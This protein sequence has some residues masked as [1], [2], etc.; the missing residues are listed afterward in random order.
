MNVAAAAP[1]MIL[2]QGLALDLDSPHL[3]IIVMQFIVVRDEGAH[4]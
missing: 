2:V 3:F 4:R 1:C